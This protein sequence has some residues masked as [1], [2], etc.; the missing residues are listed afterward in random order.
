MSDAGY[1][2]PRGCY[3]Y[4]EALRRR[5]TVPSPETLLA[6]PAKT[7]LGRRLRSLAVAEQCAPELPAV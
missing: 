2:L 7:D 4:Y 1:M 5:A 3:L 6:G